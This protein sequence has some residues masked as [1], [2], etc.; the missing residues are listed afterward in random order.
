M[1]PG[2]ICNLNLR[3]TE[4]GKIVSERTER[5]HSFV[6]NFAY[7]ILRGMDGITNTDSRDITNTARPAAPAMFYNRGDFSS[8]G[9]AGMAC[10]GE[11]GVITKGIVVGSSNTAF[12]ISQ[13][14]LQTQ[15]ANG[16]GAGQ[17]SYAAMLATPA[18]PSF[19]TPNIT[20]ELY[21]DMANNSG[22][23]I[24][25]REIG[26]KGLVQYTNN[27]V[28]PRG[29]SEIL[30]ARDVVADTVVNA[31]QVLNVKYIFKTVV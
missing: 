25:V 5:A 18:D 30:F 11:A 20:S 29:C 19:S 9:L 10:V 13:Y 12:A 16:T 17:L 23:A 4:D 15:I 7:M 2:V 6:T 26:L 3:V 8:T 27:Q 28:N 22:S 24:T 31:G 21:R 1:K 14:G